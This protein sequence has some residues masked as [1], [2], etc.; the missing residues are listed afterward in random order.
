[1]I[2]LILFPNDVELRLGLFATGISSM[3]A[4]SN[5]W[6][7]IFGGD[8]DLATVMNLINTVSVCGEFKIQKILFC[9][10]MIFN[11]LFVF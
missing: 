9:F 3:G 8:S 4:A 6:S 11:V 2:G 1:M 5:C 10:Q 7:L